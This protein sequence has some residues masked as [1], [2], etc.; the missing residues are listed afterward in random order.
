[1]VLQDNAPRDSLFKPRLA[2]V[3]LCVSLGT[4]RE[5]PQE[6]QDLSS[7]THFFCFCC[8]APKKDC[9]LEA[10]CGRIGLALGMFAFNMMLPDFAGCWDLIRG[11]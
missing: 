2:Y 8:L 5:L 11:N 1:M 4:F 6:F 9:V 3:V 7:D 10:Y